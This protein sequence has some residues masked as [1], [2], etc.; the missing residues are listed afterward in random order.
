MFVCFF[1]TEEAFP[2]DFHLALGHGRLPELPKSNG[3]AEIY[4]F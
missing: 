3:E 4:V 1:R 2:S